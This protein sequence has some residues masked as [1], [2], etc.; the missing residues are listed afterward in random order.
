MQGVGNVL[1]SLVKTITVMDRVWADCRGNERY[2]NGSKVT[3]T[4]S[5][6]G[7]TRVDLNW[8]CPHKIM[9]MQ[10]CHKW[11]SSTLLEYCK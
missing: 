4:L 9:G 7:Q 8:P 5:H 1:P 6:T 3:E 11:Y 10:L 2:M